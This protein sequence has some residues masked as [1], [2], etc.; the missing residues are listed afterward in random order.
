VEEIE[1]GKTGILEDWKVGMGERVQLLQL[2][3]WVQLF[4]WVQLLQ[5]FQWVI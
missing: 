1:D 2:L 4:Q 5:L 3:Q